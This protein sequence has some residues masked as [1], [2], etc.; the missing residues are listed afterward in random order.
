MDDFQ[1]LLKPVSGSRSNAVRLGDRGMMQVLRFPALQTFLLNE[2]WEMNQNSL[3]S[4]MSAMISN[5]I[6]DNQWLIIRSI[7]T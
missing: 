7:F 4:L 6:I 5:K 1:V 2:D 3:H